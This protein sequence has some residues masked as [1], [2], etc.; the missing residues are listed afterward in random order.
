VI[1]QLV[2][3]SRRLSDD[4]RASSAR[5]KLLMSLR[6]DWQLRYRAV[7]LFRPLMLAMSASSTDVHDRFKDSRDCSMTSGFQPCFAGLSKLFLFA[8][9]C[10][11]LKTALIPV[12][13]D[14]PS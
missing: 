7:S 14:V 5:P 1:E 13:A 8:R 3:S 12:L 11:Y 4:M 2:L 6:A 10:I 9:C